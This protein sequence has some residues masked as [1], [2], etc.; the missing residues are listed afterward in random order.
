MSSVESIAEDRFGFLWMG[1]QEGLNRFDGYQFTVHQPADRPGHLRDDFI[2]AIAPDPRGDLW[3]GTESGVQHLDTATGRFG[4]SVTPPGVGVRL[5]TLRVAPDGRLWFGG[6]FGGLWTRPPVPAA[7]ARAVATNVV[8]PAEIVTATAFG[9]AG[10]LWI[11]SAGRLLLVRTRPRGA[12]LE[13]EATPV[14]RDVG[15]VRVIHVDDEGVLWLGRVGRPV[16]RFDPARQDSTEYPNLPDHVITLASA[17]EGRLWIG[18]KDA[19]LTRFDPATGEILNYR[20]DPGDEHSL[21]ENDVAIVYEDRAGSL[22]I[23]AWNGGVSRLNL[24]AQAFR[25]LRN[26]P[27]QTDSLPD[28]DVT[29]MAEAPDGRLWTMTRNDVLAVGDPAMGSFKPVPLDRDLTALAFAGPHLFV[30]TATGLVE[31]DPATG[32]A[33]PPRQPIRAAGLDRMRIDGLH[34]R[35]GRLWI[36]A[37]RRLHCLAPNNGGETLQS[38]ALGTDDEPTSLF[39]SSP[40]RVWI[41]F[42]DAGLLLVERSASGALAVRRAGGA[43][44]SARGRLIAVIEDRGVVWIGSAR[45]FGRLDAAGRVEWLDL[46]LGMPS[47]SVA[48]IQADAEGVLWIPTN[49]GITRFEP[50]TGRAVHLGAAQGAQGSGYVDGGGA[51]GRSGLL[52]FAGRG[53]TVFHPREVVQNP[54]RPRVLF[55]ALEILHRPVLPSW[56]DAD[57]PLSTSIHAADSITLGPDAVVF[58]VEMAAPGVTDPRRVRFAHRLDGFDDAWIETP[59]NRRVATYTSLS[60]GEYLLRARSQTPAGAW[61]TEEARLRIRILPPWWRSPAAIALWFTL[62]VVALAIVIS[63][64]RRRGRVR[65]ALAEQEVLRRASVTDPLTGLYNRRFLTAWLQLEVPRTLRTHRPSGADRHPEFLHIVMVDLD[66]LKEI[67]D[68]FGHDAGDRALRAVAELLHSHAR[69]DDVAVRWGGD[70]FMLI[71]RSADRVRAADVVE[72]LRALAE[73]LQPTH[74]DASRCTLSLGFVSFPFLAHDVDAL[75]WDETMQLADRALLLSKRRGR[76]AWTGFIAT[77]A[78]TATDVLAD[79]LPDTVRVVEGPG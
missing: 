38:V 6:Q 1:T 63:E 31:L 74:G 64:T 58:S 35:D 43:A 8:G 55:T 56:L 28:D 15:F 19:G 75:T 46:E 69:A 2:R 25:T 66:N 9:R 71:L 50:A 27:A 24:Y 21:A 57:S 36:V 34:G 5:N 4:D 77:P 62:L 11:A 10:N 29:R 7:Q 53:I 54:Y 42:A 37:D 70:E 41:A 61:S 32:R 20:H 65:I 51:R 17:G 14:L 22:W 18:G 30:G 79:P 16:M 12:E 44:V 67:N 45:G 49:Q 76:N 48:D 23:G 33:L 72:R 52:Y 13:I 78:A 59:A 68:A 73:N 47:R 26:N 3:I 60:P 40:D 39:A